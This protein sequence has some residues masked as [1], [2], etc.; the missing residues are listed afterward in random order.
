MSAEQ[1]AFVRRSLGQHLATCQISVGSHFQKRGKKTNHALISQCC[2]FF[3]DFYVVFQAYPP[4]SSAL[5]L[6]GCNFI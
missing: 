1:L 4:L 6:P 3:K 2:S 5:S